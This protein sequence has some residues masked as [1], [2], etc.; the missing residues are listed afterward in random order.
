MNAWQHW[1]RSQAASRTESAARRRGWASAFKSPE[2]ESTASLSVRVSSASVPGQHW[3]A[4]EPRQYRDI[5]TVAHSDSDGA[6]R[7]SVDTITQAC[8]ASVSHRRLPGRVAG[9]AVIPAARVFCH[10]LRAPSQ[11]RSSD[12]DLTTGLSA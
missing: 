5:D 10:R 7:A 1:L 8:H 3:A 12:S 2:S 11:S 4:R 6:T 9:A